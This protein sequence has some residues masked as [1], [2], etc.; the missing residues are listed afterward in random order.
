MVSPG[1]W[2]KFGVA[3][4]G[5]RGT[6]VVRTLGQLSW[7]STSSRGQPLVGLKIDRLRNPLH[8]PVAHA[9]LSAVG[10]AAPEAVVVRPVALLSFEGLCAGEDRGRPVVEGVAA[11]GGRAVVP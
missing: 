5:R 9:E 10:M 4:V 6:P 3:G 7:P 1:R 2:R 11:S 8:G